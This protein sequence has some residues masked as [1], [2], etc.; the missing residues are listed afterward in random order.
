MAAIAPILAQPA[1]KAHARGQV[2]PT[3]AKHL[4]KQ[5]LADTPVAAVP[6]LAPHIL[7]NRA[8]W[9]HVFVAVR[10]TPSTMSMVCPGLLS[11]RCIICPSIDIVDGVVPVGICTEKTSRGQVFRPVSKPSPSSPWGPRRECVEKSFYGMHMTSE[12]E[13]T[14]ACLHAR[15]VCVCVCVCVCVQAAQPAGRDGTEP[16]GIGRL[17]AGPHC[18]A[19]RR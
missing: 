13:C 14:I 9:T 11:F 16:P 6:A 10:S 15:P 4:L 3:D 5:F 7:A 19:R 8:L 18:G 12:D 1:P 2:T 17:G